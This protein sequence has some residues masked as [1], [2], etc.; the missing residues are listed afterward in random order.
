MS[1]SEKILVI[2]TYRQPAVVLAKYLKQFE[3]RD[4]KYHILVGILNI[5]IL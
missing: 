4:I 3:T 5:N 1:T 2:A